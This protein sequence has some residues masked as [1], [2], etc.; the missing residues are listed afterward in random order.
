[1]SARCVL[2]RTQGRADSDERPEEHTMQ[3]RDAA[4]AELAANLARVTP[5]VMPPSAIA[6]SLTK[7]QNYG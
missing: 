2:D 1:M 3:L 4:L 5:D 6:L 7:T